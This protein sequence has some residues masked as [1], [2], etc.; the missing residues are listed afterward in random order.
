MITG[1][2]DELPYFGGC[3]LCGRTDGYMNIRAAHWFVCDNHRTRWFIGTNLFSSWKDET[4]ADWERS[5]QKLES[6]TEVKPIRA[7]SLSGTVN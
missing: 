7:N 5:R 1:P 6:Y 3:P 2:I 4:E